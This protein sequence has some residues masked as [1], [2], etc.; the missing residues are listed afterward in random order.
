MSKKVGNKMYI[1]IE[2]VAKLVN[3]KKCDAIILFNES[4]MHYIWSISPREGVIIVT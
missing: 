2:K 3:D 1:N 4:N